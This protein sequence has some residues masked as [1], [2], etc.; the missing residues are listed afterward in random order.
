[1]MSHP[2]NTE[3]RAHYLREMLEGGACYDSP[4]PE[5]FFSSGKAEVEAAQRVCDT[6]P[7]VYRLACLEYALTVRARYGVWGGILFWNGS[8]FYRKLNGG[9]PPGAGRTAP[10]KV[11][12]RQLWDKVNARLA[13]RKSA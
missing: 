9:R 10:G 5:L 13:I 8:T 3:A 4:N 6:C 12:K 11:T 2:I 1:M 7:A